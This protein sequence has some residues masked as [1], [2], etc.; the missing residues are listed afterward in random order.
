MSCRRCNQQ[1]G[2]DIMLL[3]KQFT[4]GV[5]SEQYKFCKIDYNST[6]K[7]KTKEVKKKSKTTKYNIK[8]LK[9]NTRI[10][11][12]KAHILKG[13]VGAKAAK[14]DLNRAI[15]ELKYARCANR[16][17]KKDSKRKN[18]TSNKKTR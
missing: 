3:P 18:N 5:T 13:Q 16:K 11:R 9:E 15:K 7:L 8:Q 4:S 10:E 2:C 17:K 6:R 12:V 1:R 14:W